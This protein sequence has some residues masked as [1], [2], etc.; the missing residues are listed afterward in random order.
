MVRGLPR[1]PFM[2]TEACSESA[3]FK[4]QGWLALVRASVFDLPHQ[5]LNLGRVSDYI[6]KVR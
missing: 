6:Y 1:H 2:Y 3:G 5:L 4:S